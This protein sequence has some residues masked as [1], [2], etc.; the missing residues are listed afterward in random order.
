MSP[1]ASDKP[2]GSKVDLELVSTKDLIN[3]VQRRSTFAGIMI[4]SEEERKSHSVSD[5][6]VFST[7]DAGS[8]VGVLEM[9][10]REVSQ[11]ES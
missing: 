3:E 11:H 8:T 5:F 10:K 9:V 1:S 7:F 2:E 6:K 4:W